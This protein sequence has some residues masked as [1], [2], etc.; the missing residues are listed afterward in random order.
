[1]FS[2]CITALV[3]PFKNEELDIDGLRENIRFQVR[4][5]VKGLLVCGST[6][7]APN[8]TEGETEKVIETAVIEAKGKVKVIAGA[9]TN[10]T[11][12]SCKQIKRAEALSVDAVLVVAPYYNKPTQEGLYR[13]FRACAEAT[14]LPLIVYNI[15]PRSVVNILP[16]TIERLIKDCPN[17]VAVKEASGSLDQTSEIIQR[18]A[19]RVTVLSGDDSLTLPILAVGGKGVISVVSNIV[20]LDVQ[21]LVDDFLSGRVEEARRRHLK[22]FPL[23]KALFIE[24]NP[25][26]IKAAMALL[27]M[28]AGEPRLP[29]CPLSSQNEPVLRQALKNY[30]LN[31]KD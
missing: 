5:G 31:L 20:P 15:P 17:I 8:L 24:T 1:M 12:K 28:P 7:E 27:G 30:G 14:G 25:I 13:H 9:G 23:I 10:S 22:L 29:L 19:E 26:P 3:T 16:A 4:A 11:H 21:A 18:C 6:G 2:G